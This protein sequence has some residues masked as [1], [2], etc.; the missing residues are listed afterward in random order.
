MEA[1]RLR[2][3]RRRI[4]NR[5]WDQV[6]VLTGQC[7]LPRLLLK[8]SQHEDG[9]LPTETEAVRQDGIDL[10]LARGVRNVVEVAV[11]VRM[12]VVDGRVNHVVRDGGD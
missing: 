4:A 11:R 1:R 8:P 5:D 6:R 3:P 2:H 10:L 7:A 9:V 12:L